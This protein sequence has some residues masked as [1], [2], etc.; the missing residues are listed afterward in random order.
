MILSQIIQRERVKAG[1]GRRNQTL[2]Q[3]NNRTVWKQ[4]TVALASQSFCL[5]PV[6]EEVGGSSTLGDSLKKML[7]CF[8]S[9]ISFILQKSSYLIYSSAPAWITSK[10]Y[11]QSCQQI[12]KKKILNWILSKYC[13]KTSNLLSMQLID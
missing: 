3:I 6:S 13:V 12:K 1:G 8:T 5:E 2:V 11:W 9:S 10:L 4:P 7:K